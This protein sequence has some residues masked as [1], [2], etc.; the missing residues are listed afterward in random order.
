ME[1]KDK[2]N[3]NTASTNRK[4]AVKR[5][6]GGGN[7]RGRGGFRG[8]GARNAKQNGSPMK[9]SQ[10]WRLNRN[11]NQN[12]V[13]G[14]FVKKRFNKNGGL[15]RSRSNLNL[16]LNLNRATP[17]N[18]GRGGLSSRRGRGGRIGL[19]RSRSRT[20]LTYAQ[21]G[22][23]TG[24]INS[25]NNNNNNIKNTLKRTNSLP[26]LR[27]PTSVHN[28]LGYQ[29]PAQVAYRNRVK[30]AKQVLLQRQNQ[31][32]NRVND[33]RVSIA[34]QYFTFTV[35]SHHIFICFSIKQIIYLDFFLI[36]SFKNLIGK[37]AE[38]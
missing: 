31:R 28:R 29:S 3:K 7:A 35:L 33:F 30:R 36:I 1:K 14:G 8:R 16:N 17:K 27:D 38:R 32:L 37:I 19:N 2:K 9:S 6:R 24:N 11:Q 4:G 21:G 18:S 34:S 15:T 12:I 25:N 10:S 22:F 23:Y 5:N 20:N 13:Q 26:N